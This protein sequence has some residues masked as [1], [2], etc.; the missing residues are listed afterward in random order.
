[1]QHR[2]RIVASLGPTTDPPG[3]LE[4]LLAAGLDVA[5]INFS[6]GTPEEAIR[7]IARFRIARSARQRY[8]LPL[9]LGP[10]TA[11]ARAAKSASA[12]ERSS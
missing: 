3:V 12:P 9:P 1:M 7:R 8:G 5:R 10:A 6:H 11:R 4:K 2:T